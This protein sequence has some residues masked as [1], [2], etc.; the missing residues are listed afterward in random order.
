MKVSII[1]VCYNSAA[2]LNSAIQSVV[3]QVYSDTEYI[4]I[5][6]GSRDGTISIVKSYGNSVAHFVSEPDM[7]IYDGMNKGIRLATGDVIAILN[8]DDFY[9]HSKVVGNV[10]QLFYSNPNVDMVL[11]NVEFIRS[12]ELEKPI[13]LVSSFRFLPWKMRFGFMP[14]HPAAFIKRSAY[15]QVGLYKINYKIGAD[16]EWFVRAFLVYKLNYLTFNETVVRMRDGGVSNSGLGS[17][18][19]ASTEI[20]HSLRENNIYSNLF[21]V[22]LRLPIKLIIKACENIVR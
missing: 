20:L 19:V 9:C 11:G 1:T 15:N 2:Y 6:A 12:R 7:G 5:D 18:W 14:A 8:S 3:G 16:F 22:L 4:I 13:R 10:V 17:H 21:F